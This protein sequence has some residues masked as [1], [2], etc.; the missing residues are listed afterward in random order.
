M[1]SLSAFPMTS[2]LKVVPKQ[3]LI[4]AS[5]GDGVWFMNGFHTHYSLQYC[6]RRWCQLGDS[7]PNGLPLSKH[8]YPWTIDGCN[9]MTGSA[10]SR[11]ARCGSSMRVRLILSRHAA[12]CGIRTTLRMPDA[13]SS[14]RLRRASRNLLNTKGRPISGAIVHGSVPQSGIW[15]SAQSPDTTCGSR[16]DG[17]APGMHNP[18][19]FIQA[20]ESQSVSGDSR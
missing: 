18:P 17:S 20:N 15:Q 14:T 6:T 2:S 7:T 19:P 5:Q 12:L 11:R 9:S 8:L 16:A 4:A 10:R 13:Q 3:L 1:A